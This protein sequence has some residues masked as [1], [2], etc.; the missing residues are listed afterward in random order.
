MAK[1]GHETL[2]DAHKLYDDD[3]VPLTTMVKTNYKEIF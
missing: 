2:F 1:N 3:K